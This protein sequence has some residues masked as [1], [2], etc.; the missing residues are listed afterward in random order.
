MKLTTEEK[1]VL[2]EIK[3]QGSADRNWLEITLGLLN[4]DKTFRKLK[5]MGLINKMSG[6]DILATS[7]GNK[8]REK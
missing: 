3:N 5:K 8:W 6:N 4:S 2:Q 1:I 7:K